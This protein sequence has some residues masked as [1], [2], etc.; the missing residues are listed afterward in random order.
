M[1]QVNVP[2]PKKRNRQIREKNSRQQDATQPLYQGRFKITTRSAAI[3]Y[4]AAWRQEV[5]R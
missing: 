5:D 1:T 4:R 3:R 2:T